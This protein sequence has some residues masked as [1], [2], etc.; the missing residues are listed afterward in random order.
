MCACTTCSS[1]C[2]VWY[3]T[4]QRET[5]AL[6][7]PFPSFRLLFLNDK[8]SID[9]RERPVRL[10]VILAASLWK[11]IASQ[12]RF[13][14]VIVTLANP[15]RLPRDWCNNIM[16]VKYYASTSKWKY[17]RIHGDNNKIRYRPIIVTTT[18]SV[19]THS[20]VLNLNYSN[21]M[22]TCTVMLCLV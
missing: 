6:S 22:L 14:A 17:E 11:Y 20:Y 1:S 15:P 8:T 7:P 2:L 4:L 9:K 3:A 18:Y 12:A 19:H 16:C 10:A 21:F 13:L 5:S